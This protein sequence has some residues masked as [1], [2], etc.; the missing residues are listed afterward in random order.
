[1]HESKGQH[2][3]KA[4]S[5]HLFHTTPDAMLLDHISLV[6]EP[7]CGRRKMAWGEGKWPGVRLKLYA[8]YINDTII[9][10]QSTPTHCLSCC[11]YVEEVPYNINYATKRVILASFPGHMGGGSGLRTRIQP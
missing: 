9:S 4:P 10:L 3:G 5:L 8:M 1:M 11:L 2:I 6:P 7:T